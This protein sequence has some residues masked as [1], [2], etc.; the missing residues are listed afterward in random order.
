MTVLN[1][2]NAWYKAAYLNDHF[3]TVSELLPKGK[4]IF[5][6]YGYLGDNNFG[7]ELVFE[8]AKKLFHPHVLLPVRKRMP[9]HLRAYS[10]IFSSQIAGI[11]IGGGTLIGP[12]FWDGDFFEALATEG[13]PVYVHGTGVKKKGVYNEGWKKIFAGNI[14]GGVRGP[15]SKAHL[16]EI[17]IN[18]KVVGDA[19]LN[20]FDSS[21]SKKNR[22]EK[23]V[24]INLGTHLG[25]IGEEASRGELEKFIKTLIQSN[26]NVK[27][28]PF[29]RIDV[30]LGSQLKNKYPQITLLNIPNKYCDA[31]HHFQNAVFAIGE[32][33]HF[34]VMA[35]LAE[36][37]FLSI[38]YARKHED[39]LESMNLS[40][41]GI[42]PATI[43]YDAITSAFEN[44][45]FFDW[46]SLGNR[47]NNLK[48]IQQD[49]LC[50]YLR[51]ARA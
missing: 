22:N 46:N 5:A 14:F 28:L 4:K 51:S 34:T 2:L 48:K 42:M 6:Y 24:L 43:S 37:P 26:F 47:I 39:F 33:L 36:C 11:V 10:K 21:N 12:L 7:D 32:R 45:Q 29:H 9:V 17:S 30:Q 16:D 44:R 13:K 25:Y 15:L 40:Q 19:A 35:L 18:M 41:A 8:S 23:N 49:E 38:N 31:L 20:M 3:P 1:K 50:E 27:F